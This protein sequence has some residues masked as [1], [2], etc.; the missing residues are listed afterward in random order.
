M[1]ISPP[2]SA[3]E[4]I[5]QLTQEGNDLKVTVNTAEDNVTLW[6]PGK[7]FK[8]ALAH[9]LLNAAGY[10]LEEACGVPDGTFGAGGTSKGG[11]GG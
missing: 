7:G 6:F 4:V 11:G 8:F 2:T 1:S 10:I 5:A 3:A 9:W